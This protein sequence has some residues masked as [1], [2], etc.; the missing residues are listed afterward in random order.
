MQIHDKN[1]LTE[2]DKAH[3]ALFLA[4]MLLRVPNHRKNI[5][6][7]HAEIIKRFTKTWASNTKGFEASLR[8][9]EQETGNKID[10]PV[11]DLQEFAADENR[12]DIAVNP[13]FSL[14]MIKSVP[15]IANI[16][17]NMT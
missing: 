6:N 11:K 5:E 13:Q 9:Y 7:A 16:L 2:E 4:S 12:Y 10:I 8:K 15:E 14:G 1:K 17:R 3:V